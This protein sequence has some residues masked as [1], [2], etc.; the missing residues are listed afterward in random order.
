MEIFEVFLRAS[1]RPGA[2]EK[3]PGVG[4]EVQGFDYLVPWP[5]ATEK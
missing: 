2:E 5:V 4:A 3:K 1:G